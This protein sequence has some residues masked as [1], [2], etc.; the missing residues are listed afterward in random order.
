MRS[1]CLSWKLWV[2]LAAKALQR[3]Q[4]V[5]KQ[6]S[7]IQ[8]AKSGKVQSASL[9]PTDVKYLWGSAD[10]EALITVITE[11]LWGWKWYVFYS[12]LCNAEVWRWYLLMACGF[13]KVNFLWTY[14]DV[15]IE[16]NIYG[17]SVSLFFDLWLEY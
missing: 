14:G 2:C 10:L 17:Q 15:W 9:T 8:G 12:L 11:L 16:V 4:D 7:G 13:F 1:D 6:L 5:I 3:S